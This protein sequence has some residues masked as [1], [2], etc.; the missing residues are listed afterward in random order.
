MRRPRDD[1]DQQT[2]LH[3]LREQRPDAG[4]Q[5]LGTVR[6]SPQAISMLHRQF[7]SQLGIASNKDLRCGPLAG[8]KRCVELAI[9]D[10]VVPAVEIDFAIIF[11]ESAAHAQKL[12]GTPVA[13]VVFQKV[14]I[15]ALLSRRMAGY[16]IQ[17]DTA[18]GKCRNSIDLLHRG[19]WRLIPDRTATINFILLVTIPTP[20]ART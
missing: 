6:H 19:R 16:H 5:H 4:S 18:L 2:D 11:P 13:F 17:T 8:N 3:A 15:A 7:F 20:A 1:R 14:A 12:V 9:L 10:S